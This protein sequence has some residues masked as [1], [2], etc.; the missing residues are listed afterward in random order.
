MPRAKVPKFK[1]VLKTHK[2]LHQERTSSTQAF[3]VEVPTHSVPQLT[4]IMKNVTKDSKTYVPFQMRRNNP[5][6]F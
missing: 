1:M 4:S 3:T 5:D 6:A 2:I